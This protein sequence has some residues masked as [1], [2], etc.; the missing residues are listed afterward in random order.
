[1]IQVTECLDQ[2]KKDIEKHRNAMA[3]AK[4]HVASQLTVLDLLLSV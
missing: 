4:K 2:A 3:T 1:V